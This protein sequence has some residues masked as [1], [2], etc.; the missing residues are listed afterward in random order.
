MSDAYA[1]WIDPDA[2]NIQ[3]LD[4]SGVASN[5]SSFAG[6]GGGGMFGSLGGGGG[7][8]GGMFGSFAA[9]AGDIAGAFGDL[10]EASAYKEAAT[11]ATNDAQIAKASGAIQTYQMQRKINTTVGGQMAEEGA[12][13][14]SMQGSAGDIRR[15]SFSQGALA[16]QLIGVQ[17]SINVN[18]YT[19]EASSARAMASAASD[20]AIG[21]F[22]GGAF[23]VA[24]GVTDAFGA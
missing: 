3:E 20:A 10:A 24:G 4:T 23:Q 18:N 13:G 19:Q 15:A 6:G 8:G 17:T 5:Y 7:G 11:I 21:G 1:P 9:A 16:K 22:I 12:A 14:F 2:S